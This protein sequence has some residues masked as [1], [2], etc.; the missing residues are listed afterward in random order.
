LSN[1]KGES[2]SAVLCNHV[3]IAAHD[4]R[5]SASC[6]AELFGLDEPTFY[7]PFALVTL[8]GRVFLQFA[9]PGIDDIQLQ[10]HAFLVD[11][12]RFDEIYQRLV[13][14]RIE[15]RADPQMAF[16]GQINTNQA[17]VASTSRTRAATAWWC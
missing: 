16:P 12:E 5:A 6:F 4:Q 10:H 9:E 2:T 11:D 15:H 8:D 3:I 14:A 17:A 7:G 1:R 13:D